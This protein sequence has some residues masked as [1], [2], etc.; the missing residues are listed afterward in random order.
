LFVAGRRRAEA[1]AQRPFSRGAGPRGLREYNSERVA[2]PA[3]TRGCASEPEAAG[4]RLGRPQVAPS[5]SR[6]PKRVGLAAGQTGPEFGPLLIGTLQRG[7]RGRARQVEGAAGMR[8]WRGA[9]GGQT[10]RSGWQSLDQIGRVT[11]ANCC[12]RRG[13]VID[14]PPASRPTL[15]WGPTGLPWTSRGSSAPSRPAS[16]LPKLAAGQLNL[17]RR[18][19]RDEPVARQHSSVS[20]PAGRLGL[21]ARRARAEGRPRRASCKWPL[22]E[23]IVFRDSSSRMRRQMGASHSGGH[24]IRI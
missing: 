11:L 21:L 20:R 6:G 5:R 2:R 14:G 1:R 10:S 24:L 23:S 22:D 19:P 13:R 12:W 7:G 15:S 17:V 4:R 3:R 16:P 9:W 8:P 18:P